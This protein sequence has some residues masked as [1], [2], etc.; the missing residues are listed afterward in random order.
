MAKRSSAECRTRRSS[1]LRASV[2]LQAMLPHSQELTIAVAELAPH[3]LVD[4]PEEQL[5]ASGAFVAGRRAQDAR[6]PR[7]EAND[8]LGR[9]VACDDGAGELVQ[10]DPVRAG[11]SA[12]HAERA[13]DVQ[14]EALREHPLRLLDRDP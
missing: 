12:Q 8:R 14:P 3:R 13:V 10:L 7:Q 11:G 6:M 9:L 2:S 1:A 4:P 5:R